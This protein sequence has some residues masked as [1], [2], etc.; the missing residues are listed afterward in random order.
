MKKTRDLRQWEARRKRGVELYRKGWNQYEIAE[1]LGVTQ[2]SVSRWVRAER[3]GGEAALDSHPPPGS[4]RKI[5][6]DALEEL[7][8]L[9]L[10]SPREF[11]FESELWTSPMVTALIRDRF[12][13][14]YHPGNV[15]KILRRIGFSPQKPIKRATQRD[16]AAIEKWK[17]EEWP[18][19]KKKPKR[20]ARR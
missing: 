10:L 14:Q 1:V 5:G 7:K 2:P 8:R 6:D 15:R 19:I 20:E 18:R 3:A 13:V 16:E 12:G 11:G 9:L 17:K 4:E